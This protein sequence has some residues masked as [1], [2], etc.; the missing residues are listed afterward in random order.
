MQ[1]EGNKLFDLVRNNEQFHVNLL[2]TED[3]QNIK[4]ICT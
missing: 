2:L 1:I 3:M 4:V